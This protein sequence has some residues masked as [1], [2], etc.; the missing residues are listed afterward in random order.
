MD[1]AADALPPHVAYRPLKTLRPEVDDLWIIDEPIVR[2]GQ[3][4]LKAPFQLLG[5]ERLLL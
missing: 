3:L 4:K 1:P 5:R 2:L